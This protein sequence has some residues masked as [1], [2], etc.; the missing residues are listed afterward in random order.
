VRGHAPFSFV[1]I[2]TSERKRKLGLELAAEA[3][4]LEKERVVEARD[5]FGQRERPRKRAFQAK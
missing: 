1:K 5:N 3:R 2:E 4:L